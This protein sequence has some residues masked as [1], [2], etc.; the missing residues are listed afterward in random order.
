MTQRE[1][2][3]L[4]VFDLQGK[5]AHSEEMI[6]SSGTQKVTFDTFAMRKGTYFVNVSSDNMNESA[7]MVV[8]K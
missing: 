3:V 4:R 7:Q 8:V 2:V 1:Q 5:I 6:L